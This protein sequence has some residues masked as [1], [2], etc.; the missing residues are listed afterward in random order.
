MVSFMNIYEYESLHV[1]PGWRSHTLNMWILLLDMWSDTVSDI[2]CVCVIIMSFPYTTRHSTYGGASRNENY[3]TVIIWLL[4]LKPF[5][6]RIGV[7][8]LAFSGG[9]KKTKRAT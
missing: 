1:G 3:A 8:S 2:M 4:A 5:S 9:S 6:N 7:K